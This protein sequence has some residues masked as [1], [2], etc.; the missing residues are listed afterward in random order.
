M[1]GSTPRNAWAPDFPW[2]ET[3]EE[4]EGTVASIESAWGTEEFVREAWPSAAHDENVVRW[5]AG[6]CRN[7]M[8]PRAAAEYERMIYGDDGRDILPAIRVPTMILHRELDSPECNQYFAEQIH[9]AEYVALPGGEHIPYI[10]DQ[11]SV[12]REIERFVR[13]VREEEALINRQLATVLFTDIVSSAQTAATLGD[14]AWRDVVEKH[15][16]AVRGLLNRYKGTEVDTAGDGFFA[17][18]DGPAR[19]ARCA[20]TIVDAVRP[21]GIQVRAGLHTGEVETIAGKTGGITVVIGARVG[22]LAQPSEVLASRTVRDLTAGSGLRFEDAG[23]H[24][25]KGVPDRWQ[26]YRVLPAATGT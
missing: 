21:L 6:L 26:R 11:D 3:R 12:T 4:H 24:E 13:N 16:T 20:Q 15:H 10:G 25:L 22:A 19:A 18:F 14:R 17:T 9:G 5:I 23:E 8:S 2:G 7:A 1:I